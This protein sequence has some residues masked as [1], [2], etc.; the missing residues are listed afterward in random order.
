M[1]GLPL[2][3]VTRVVTEACKGKASAVC[4]FDKV[5][6]PYFDGLASKTSDFTENSFW[7][8]RPDPSNDDLA[9]MKNKE[10]A[11]A[12][13]LLKRQK[14]SKTTRFVI[15]VDE[16]HEAGTVDTAIVTAAV[17]LPVDSYILGVRDSK[18]GWDE[19]GDVAARVLSAPD[20]HVGVSVV[21]KAEWE[22][23]EF[24]ARYT[25]HV[26]AVMYA[27]QALH[28]A[29]H[30]LDNVAILRDGAS[31]VM[32]SDNGLHLFC[33][34]PCHSEPRADACFYSVAAASMVATT[35][36]R[37]LSVEKIV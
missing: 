37:R 18:V 17:C 26:R 15:G 7:G 10:A 22:G 27:L 25:G 31:P 8:K 34:K 35:L 29:G 13:V 16:S 33:G 14:P 9:T 32:A 21:R 23:D 2:R 5:L 28:S 30:S 1:P 19:G 20:S 36:S 4:I 11:V 12:A 6:S 3:G 24:Y